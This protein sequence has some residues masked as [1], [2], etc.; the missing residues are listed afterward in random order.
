VTRKTRTQPLVPRVAKVAGE[1]T[2][3]VHSAPNGSAHS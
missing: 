2:R 3:E 1:P